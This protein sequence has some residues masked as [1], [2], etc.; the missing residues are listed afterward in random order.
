[1][2]FD[3]SHR[4]RTS[5]RLAV[6]AIVLLFAHSAPGQLSRSATS[7]DAVWEPT[8]AQLQQVVSACASLSRDGLKRC[9]VEGM[10]RAGASP[11]AVAFTRAQS[12]VVYLRHVQPGE[13]VDIAI[14]ERPFRANDL[15]GIWLLNGSPAQTDVDDVSRLPVRALERDPEYAEL[16]KAKL[17]PLLLPG[18]RSDAGEL[19]EEDLGNGRF[20]IVVPYRVA[21]GC[22]ACATL[23]HARFGYEFDAVG[24]LTG[25][26]FV[27]FARGEDDSELRSVPAPLE[28]STAPK[29]IQ[30]LYQ[31]TREGKEARVIELLEEARGLVRRREGVLATG[32]QGRT[33]LHWTVFAST[34]F[35]RPK[36][37][38]VCEEL[39][40]D[41]IRAGVDVNRE[42]QYQNTALDYLDQGPNDQLQTLLMEFGAVSGYFTGDLQ[43][44]FSDLFRRVETASQTGDVA[45]VRHEL[46]ADLM[47]GQTIWA[48][49][50]T[51]I[52]SQQSWTGDPIEAVVTAP[53]MSGG[54]VVLAPGTKIEG[55]VYYSQ[56]A[57]NKYSTARLSLDFA[58]IVHANGKRSPVFLRLTGVDNAREVIRNNE[59]HGITQPH[60]STKAGWGLRLVG[61]SH[62][63]LAWA[64]EGIRTA[65]G[66]SLRR[67]ILYPAGT[68]VTLQVIGPSNLAEKPDWKGWNELDSDPELD[69]LVQRS[70]VRTAT[71]KSEPSDLTTMMFLGS[72]EE[73]QA[74]FA[75]AGWVSAD[76]V[77]V[78]SALKTFQSTVRKSGYEQAPMSTLTIEGQPP[79]LVF[80]KALNTFARRHHV[81][82]WKQPGQYRGRD[83]WI[84]SGTQDTGIGVQ[85]AKKWFHR[86]DP[87]IDRERARVQTDLLFTQGAT[88]YALVE[89]P[90]AP[91]DAENATGDKLLTDG[92]MLVLWLTEMPPARASRQDFT[93]QLRFEVPKNC[94]GLP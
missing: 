88:R 92:R 5:T 9:F 11:E 49:M 69:R 32:P 73:V 31:S 82:I 60:A 53:L 50:I 71:P 7:A 33:A 84:S 54:R 13:V 25:V 27:S 51:P 2:S 70:P 79:D 64:I 21:S 48:R 39:A 34:G 74:A 46:A 67:E 6:C 17:R 91:K 65:Y 76:H 8:P 68:D 3:T 80:Q 90:R 38:A 81:R 77:N 44:R 23:G 18:D 24:K 19:G 75:K 42:D 16:L 15:Q 57:P 12:D 47:P 66:L 56:T 61:M 43:E 10:S 14:V 20:R 28:M 26:S 85:G 4:S 89:R 40:L 86:I 63:A 87:R 22:R 58:N 52:G 41:L 78:A 45:R 30:V 83:I 55:T 35:S 72:R 93:V 94:S 36:I 62:P 37:L 29:L 1:M 59:I